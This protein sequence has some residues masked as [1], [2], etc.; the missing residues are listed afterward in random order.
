VNAALPSSPASPAEVKRLIALLIHTELKLEELTAGEVD[1]VADSSGT[2]LLLRHA[3][4]RL[5]GQGGR[6]LLRFGGAMDAVADPMY[7]TDRSTMKLIHINDAACKA[8]GLSRKESLELDPWVIASMTRRELE[9]IYDEIIGSGVDAKPVELLRHRFDGTPLWVEVRRHPQRTDDGWTII[10]LVRDISERKEA[11]AKL[12]RLSR[13]YAMLSGINT[14]IVHVDSRDELFSEACRIAVDTGGFRM[15]WIGLV[16]A[17]GE[18]VDLVAWHGGEPGFADRSSVS[19]RTT[20]GHAGSRA[21]TSLEAEICN[22]ISAEP[23][24]APLRDELLRSGH[25]AMASF[26]LRLSGRREAVMALFAGE[27]GVFDTEETALLMQLAR[28]LSFAMGHIDR[29]AKLQYIAYYDE[30]TG[31]ANL[32][33]FLDR[34]SQDIR[35]ATFEERTCGVVMI[36]IQRFKNIN[37]T[38]GR[39]AGD[40]LLTQVAQWLT[41][42][43]GDERLLARVGA[44]R[45]ALLIPV[46]GRG[47]VS[48]S[49]ESTMSAILEHP[50]RVNDTALR[51]SARAGIA[52]FPEDGT[53]A[54]T[55]FKNAEAAL[56]NAKGRGDRIL[57]HQQKMTEAVGARLALENKL[58]LALHNNQFVLHYQPKT[59]LSTGRLT[60]V[61]ALLRWDDPEL[62]L[63]PPAQFVPILEETG[64]ILGVGRWAMRQ[65]IRDFLAWKA[66]G[67]PVVRVAVNVSPLQLRQAN[68]IDEVRAAIAVAPEAV[69][70]LELEIT[71]SLLME[72]VAHT[73]ETLQLV[74]DLG[75][76]VAIDDF[77]TGFSSLAYLSKLPVDALKIDRSFVLDMNTTPRGLALVSTIINL[78]H[79]MDLTVVAEGV[80]TDDQCRLLR[81]LKCDEYQGF[82]RSPA[83]PA[84]QFCRQFLSDEAQHSPPCEPLPTAANDRAH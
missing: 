49:L 43:I 27:T 70:A 45:F 51:I 14:L 40:S 61:E 6:A 16:D 68:F 83:V 41:Q 30:L 81:L 10:T 73:M 4:Y 63:M 77:G 57:F 55:L 8:M 22:D 23:T 64:L 50:F 48:R 29:E 74:R 69:D 71:E 72:D 18:C 21:L 76:R 78:A 84:T 9:G 59:S 1:A 12:R 54:D 39:D 35:T 19:A 7:L 26:P 20:G 42:Q 11:N 52:L 32:K 5:H 62:G 65:A 28:D 60:G 44:D 82:L 24:L 34:V 33:L 66:R 56:K 2:T 67:L 13:V 15:A 25:H 47:D 3:Q 53:D 80:E 75:V 58:G 31:L 17:D 38:F 79:A 37:D 46:A 36:D